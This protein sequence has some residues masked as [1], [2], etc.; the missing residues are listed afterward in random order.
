M[1]MSTPAVTCESCL[2]LIRICAQLDTVRCLALFLS[3]FF[4]LF[5]II[6]KTLLTQLSLTGLQSFKKILD[7]I[8][9]NDA[10]RDQKLAIL[11]G[12][13]Q[14]AQPRE[15]GEDAVFLN[16]IMEMWSFASQVNDDGVM[17]AVAV[18]LALLLQVVSDSLE[19]V[20]HGLGVCQT[21]L[22]ERQLKSISR[23][24]SSEK[25]KGFIISPTLRLLRE[26]VCL[27][28]GAFAK[29]IFRARASTFTSLGRNLEIAP[30]GDSRED[31]RKASVRT[32][33]VRFFL[34]PQVSQRRW[35]K[36]TFGAKGIALASDLYDEE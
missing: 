35:Q 11:R 2:P 30:T 24:L 15:S 4:F 27:D 36:G 13:L 20:S 32:H 12:Y 26:A 28:G 10:D 17:S 34:L 25:G 7:D 21:L 31:V 19:L 33:A 29:R 18:V 1:K 5:F 16:D 8:I 6:K 23:N 9:A 3:L 22:Q 14:A